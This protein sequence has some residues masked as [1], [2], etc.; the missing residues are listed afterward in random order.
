MLSYE[1]LCRYPA[2]FPSLTG[3]T[4]REFDALLGRFRQAEAQRRDHRS[5]TPG[6]VAALVADQAGPAPDEVVATRELYE[7]VCRRFSPRERRNDDVPRNAVLVESPP[8]RR[9]LRRVRRLRHRS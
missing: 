3:M 2:A 5:T 9:Q 4:H 1:E 8:G 7:E 6:Q